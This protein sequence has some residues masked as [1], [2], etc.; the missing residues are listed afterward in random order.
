MRTSRAVPGREREDRNRSFPAQL[1]T[2]NVNVTLALDLSIRAG[3]DRVKGLMMVAPLDPVAPGS[4]IS[5]WDTAGTPNQLMEPSI[6][7]D[8]TSSVTPPQDLTA[9]LMTDIGWFS[10]GDG[11]PDGVDNCISSDLKPTVVIAGC[12]SRA[13]NDVQANGC[14]VADDVEQC[15]TTFINKP[16]HYLACVAKETDRL[17]K[18]K[19]ITSKE[20]A[21]VL[22]CS[23][24]TL[25]H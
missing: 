17:R 7:I 14:S 22:I 23:L 18:A 12:N 15:G 8:L 1:V 3:A 5:H 16:L 24:L 13:G 11:V 25:G 21:G 9:S 2:Q 6:N 4:S 19:I 10:D 20:Q